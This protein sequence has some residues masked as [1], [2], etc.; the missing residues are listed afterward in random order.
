MSRSTSVSI[1]D[2]TS[3][4]RRHWRMSSR[5]LSRSFANRRTP[6]C[7]ALQAGDWL[8]AHLLVALADLEI[9][10]DLALHCNLVP[11]APGRAVPP[12]T[13]ATRAG[14][15]GLDRRGR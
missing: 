8:V 14:G 12:Q 13:V 2:V 7:G 15:L 4:C 10:R 6:K 5:S 3:G 9:G 11:R 1:T